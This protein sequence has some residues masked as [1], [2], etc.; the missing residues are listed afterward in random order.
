MLQTI[1]ATSHK[2]K[3]TYPLP[4]TR[5]SPRLG[6]RFSGPIQNDSQ[7][8]MATKLDAGI[9]RVSRL[10]ILLSDAGQHWLVHGAVG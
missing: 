8:R 6:D 4:Q 1:S 7:T 5:Y 9:S 10:F 3:P 2:Q